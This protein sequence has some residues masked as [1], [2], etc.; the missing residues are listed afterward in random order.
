MKLGHRFGNNAVS[1]SDGSNDDILANGS[2]AD[3][4]GLAFTHSIPKPNFELY[5]DYHNNSLDNDGV[6]AT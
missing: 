6:T 5:A 2:E 1:I 3:T 4:I